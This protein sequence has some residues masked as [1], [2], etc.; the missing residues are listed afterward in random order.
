MIAIRP[1]TTDDAAD[2]QALYAD[3]IAEAAWLPAPAKRDPILAEVS[4]G[5]VLHV[6][7]TVA[8]GVVGF[9]SVQPA[10]AFIHHLYV[11]PA[12]RGR[13]VGRAL[14]GSLQ[15]WLPRPW[16]LKCVSRNVDAL[17]FYRRL[18]WEALEA[19]E[20]A[21][22]SY[23]LLGFPAGGTDERPPESRGSAC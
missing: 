2:L 22:G 21:H 3:C 12:A 16:R 1:A 4:V 10:E 19:G 5:E 15:A 23:L 14:L 13:S 20:S 7:E 9:V 18:G 6:A 8:E 17:R 11:H